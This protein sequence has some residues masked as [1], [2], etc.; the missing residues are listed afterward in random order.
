MDFFMG[1]LAVNVSSGPFYWPA[2]SFSGVKAR[3]AERS[4]RAVWIPPARRNNAKVMVPW[5]HLAPVRDFA[6]R[7]RAPG[8]SRC[9]CAVVV[10]LVTGAAGCQ[11]GGHEKSRR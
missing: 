10:V 7:A 8:G 3:G 5:P 6:P 4:A 9:G 11:S 1:F 2:F